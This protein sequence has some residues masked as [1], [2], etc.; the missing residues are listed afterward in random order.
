MGDV[1]SIGYIENIDGTEIVGW[2][3]DPSREDFSDHVNLIIGSYSYLIET[4]YARIDVEIKGFNNN[5]VV[6]DLI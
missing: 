1:Q 6:L 4:T 5:N 3:A 2:S